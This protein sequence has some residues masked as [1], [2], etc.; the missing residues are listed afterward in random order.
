MCLG[1]LSDLELLWM[2]R[3]ARMQRTG[4]DLMFY[5]RDQARMMLSCG[6]RP[7]Q[8]I[9]PGNP[10]VAVDF[11]RKK[12]LSTL[13]ARIRFKQFVLFFWSWEQLLCSATSACLNIIKCRFLPL[14]FI[15]CFHLIY[16]SRQ[17]ITFYKKT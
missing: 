6:A 16:T 4:E 10:R 15:K 14:Y 13:I 17:S 3:N 1:H 2:E 7:K 9:C 8:K 5:S 12:D 11:V